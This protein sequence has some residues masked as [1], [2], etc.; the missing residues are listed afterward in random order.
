MKPENPIDGPE[1]D[2]FG[3]PSEPLKDPRGRP[4]FAKSKENQQVVIDL[5]GQKFT[6]V[7]IAEYLGCDEKT[8]R[9]HFS[10]EL[11]KGVTLLRGQAALVRASK[12]R[13]G[14]MAATKAILDE[15]DLSTG[16]RKQPKPQAPKGKKERLIDSASKPPSGWGDLLNGKPN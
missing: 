14:N 12:M 11:E 15:A 7:E 16:Q 4:A 3:N 6:R 10:R 5:V 13:M 2:L 1:T 9:K 8:L